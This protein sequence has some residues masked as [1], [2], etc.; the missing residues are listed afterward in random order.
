MLEILQLVHEINSFPEVFYERGALK[1]FS[2]FSDK[3]KKLSSS[4]A[5][6]SKDVYENLAKLT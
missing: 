2:K 1:N 5:V 4:I 3:H 6:L